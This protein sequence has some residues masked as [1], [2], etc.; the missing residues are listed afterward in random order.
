LG[1]KFRDKPGEAWG[2]RGSQ[3]E[4]PGSQLFNASERDGESWRCVSLLA[5]IIIIISSGVG[6]ECCCRRWRRCLRG[7]RGVRSVRGGS[8]GSGGSGAVVVAVV[9]VV[10]AATAATVNS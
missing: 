8:G 1:P 5:S 3:L 6:V 9:A 10:A 2:A 4:G 7:V